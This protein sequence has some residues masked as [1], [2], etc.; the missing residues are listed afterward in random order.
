MRPEL[1]TAEAASGMQEDSMQA[2]I[3]F[4]TTPDEDSA[5]KIA[6]ALVEE[7]LAACVQVLPGATSF[8]RWEGK[9]EKSDEWLIIIKTSRD[10]LEELISK[11]ESLHPYEVPELVAVEAAGGARKYLD[12]IEQ[13]TTR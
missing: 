10:R 9:L 11:V 2:M 3:L 13:E 1:D 4:S 7:H 5:A 8:Y 6:G 12:W